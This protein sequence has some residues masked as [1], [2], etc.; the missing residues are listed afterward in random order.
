M[1]GQNYG[2]FVEPNN[3]WCCDVVTVSYQ[4]A[5]TMERFLTPWITDQHKNYLWVVDNGS[6]DGTVAHVKTLLPDSQYHLNSDNTGYAIAA[7]QGAHMGKQAYIAFIN[8][9]CFV[10]PDTVAKL[11][12]ELTQQPQTGLAGCRVVNEDGSLQAASC[13]RLPTF[14]RV[15]N[16]M[17]GLYRFGLPGIN[18][19]A[20]CAS[21]SA[22]VEA[23]NGALF[24]IRR[25]LFEQLNGFDEAYPLHFED[26]DLMQ[27]CLTAGYR[28]R[29]LADQQA[30]H[31]KGQSSVNYP[32]VKRWKR[33]G[34][35]RYFQKHRPGW[36]QWLVNRLIGR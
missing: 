26:L 36:E 11:V 30:I 4:N 23:V 24:V 10:H 20:T 13:R 28:I 33:Q 15:F 8:P 9:D 12:N 5:K 35:K 18:K 17:T 6:S 25:D 32:A 14:W 31:L 19:S 2:I 7:N 21:Q 3:M 1:S 34:L 16:H 22:Y 27:R 29:Y